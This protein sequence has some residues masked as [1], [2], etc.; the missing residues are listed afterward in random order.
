MKT[1]LA[2]SALV[3]AA[4]AS[5]AAQARLE[6]Y[7][8]DA[9]RAPV[10][11]ARVTW[12]GVPAAQ[13]VTDAAGRFELALGEPGEHILSV[14]ASGFV[15]AERRLL[16]RGEDIRLEIVL[17]RTAFS[18]TVAVTA[19]RAPARL[20]DTPA[21]V[22]ALSSEDLSAA[23]PSPIDEVLREVPGFTLFR[24]S[25]SRTANPTSQGVSLRGIGGSGASRAAVFDDG[26]PL[27]DPFGG[28]IAWGRV[29]RASL[30]RVEV[31]SGGAS[32]LYGGPALS[33]AIALFRRDPS[34][35]SAAL[36]SSYGS[37]ATPEASASLSG[38]TGPWGAQVAAEAFRTDGYI[39]VPESERGP[40]DRQVASRH[41][42]ADL[43]LQRGEPGKARAFLRGSYF[44]ESRENG[45]ALQT[46]DTIIRQIA[47][48]ADWP[49]ASGSASLRA[50]GMNEAYHQTFS[51]V[52][53]DRRT[54]TLA[55]AQEVP[56]EAFGGAG[57]WTAEFS[58]HRLVAGLEGRQVRGSSDETIF[59]G[60]GT[61]FARSRGTQRSGALFLEDVF[62]AGS[63]W[64]VTAGARL[65]AWKN[66][67]AERGTGPSPGELANERLPDRSE[68]A[69]SPRLALLYRA[70]PALALTGSAYGSFRPPTL[71]ELYRTFRLG[72]VVTLAN[73][74]L[75]A[76]RLRGGE[77]GAIL[78]PAGGT[79]A[80]RA[81]FFWMEVSDTIANVTLTSTP[82]LVTR[83]RQ[84][85]GRTRSRGV[86]AEAEAQL[87]D[88]VAL[89][90][91]YL[92]A[93][94]TVESFPAN[95]KLEGLRVPQVPRHQ[96]TLQ[97]R[98]RFP[99][100]ALVSVQARGA[101]AQFED[102]ENAFE[103]G[104]FVVFDALASFPVTRALE[105]FI[106]GENLLDRRYDIAR[107]P[108]RNTAPPRFVR[109]GLRLR[110]P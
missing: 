52:S 101:T 90:A 91:G 105:L 10:T 25:S 98:L 23:P 86:E 45:T 49:V 53:A 29:P 93:D 74:D 87:T 61:S 51:S 50:Y 41:E 104:S 55:R 85:L 100:G 81:V 106:A 5:L 48:G 42:T 62:A 71:N 96:G 13:T 24:R 97:A 7:V 12:S 65:D 103:L 22:V 21:S 84:N 11:G 39:P 102:D 9:A 72:N 16:A 26:I 2:G 31:M 92:Y 66:L 28:W 38:R 46:N 8:R 94:S 89:A 59:S 19:A 34:A 63:R 15:R 18:E 56:S 36:E 95:R 33:G 73:S 32:S 75:A 64:S 35:D 77:A 110:L 43:T 58:A 69:V 4:S 70:G 78:S 99:S 108:I 17:V 54:E 76:E 57:Q 60:G 109:G 14:E 6:G 3:L 27:N 88:R 68:T 37:Q 107:T 82:T 40:V 83:Q 1:I 20:R 30:E 80:L 44:T 67:D 47:A 79:A